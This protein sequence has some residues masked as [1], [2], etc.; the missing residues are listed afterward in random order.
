MR[1]SHCAGSIP[2]FKRSVESIERADSLE[3]ADRRGRGARRTAERHP[4]HRRCSRRPTIC[5]E[6]E[7]LRHRGDRA[8]VPTHAH[9]RASHQRAL[10]AVARGHATYAGG[11]W[12]C[13]ACR[14]AISISTRARCRPYEVPACSRRARRAEAS[15]SMERVRASSCCARTRRTN[16][17]A[18]TRAPRWKQA[19]PGG[20][21]LARRTVSRKRLPRPA[22]G[23]SCSSTTASSSGIV[24]ARAGIRVARPSA[25]ARA[26]SSRS[27][28]SRP[29]TTS[30]TP[31]TASRASTASSRMQRGERRG[32]APAPHVRGRSQPV[33]TREPHRP[34]PALHRQRS[35]RARST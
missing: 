31:C 2:C 3:L 1:S 35:G 25:Q 14:R 26:R 11:I 16:A 12:C 4:A 21:E 22:A 18:F 7:P 23:T 27:S 33:R 24:G 19:D 13:R 15:S 28:S 6:I 8:E 10:H 34:R 30:C 5:I 32:R 20:V 29:A 17:T 9:A